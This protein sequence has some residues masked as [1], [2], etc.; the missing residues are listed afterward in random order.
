LSPKTRT[1]ERKLDHIRIC[2][3]ENVQSRTASTGFE[4][5]HLLHKAL[6]EINLREVDTASAILGHSLSAPIIIGAM[7][8][9]TSEAAKINAVLAEAAEELGIGMGVGSQRAALESPQL[10]QTYYVARAK[11]PHIFL[12]ANLGCPQFV[13]G[14]SV[15]EARRAVEMIK[16]DALAVHLNP[17]QE[18]VQVEGQTDFK[19]ALNKLRELAHAL[20]VPVVVKETGAGIAAEEAEALE[21]AG[22]KAIDVSGV[23]GTSW[24]AV[25]YHRA[26]HSRR[27]LSERLG[28]S[29]W[30]WGI[31][32]VVSLVEVRSSTRL[33]VIAGG[34]I[35]SGVDV[36]KALALGADA[37]SLALPLLKAAVGGGKQVLKT[38]Q[39]I[40]AELRVAMFL[41]GARSVQE[42]KAKPVVVTGKTAEWLK[43][44]GF[45]PEGY[46]KRGC[47]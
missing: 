27:G 14:Y 4:D 28:L 20:D 39:Y 33:P 8:G 6:P 19:G 43:A 25:E 46:A 2:L 16:A 22:V 18:A 15:E 37:V 38:L 23:G 10:T 3:K 29:F 30:D 31:P 26:K 9:G 47:E 35:R 1:E 36:A 21:D 12:M 41:T 45:T 32:T 5:V 44:R 24:A 13:K 7:T 42:L 40:V 11:A 34:G 17:L